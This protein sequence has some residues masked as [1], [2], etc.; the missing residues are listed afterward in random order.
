VHAQGGV[1]DG[2][3]EA[4]E[5]FRPHAER[6]V[7]QEAVVPGADGA[8]VRLGPGPAFLIGGPGR[9]AVRHQG[10]RSED[11]FYGSPGADFEIGKAVCQLVHCQTICTEAMKISEISSQTSFWNTESPQ[12]TSMAFSP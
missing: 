8:E 4:G 1:L 10:R 3:R 12:G 11:A 9:K 6:D 7:D 2:S 5:V